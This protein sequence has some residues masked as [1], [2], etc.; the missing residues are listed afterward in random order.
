VT[1][2]SRTTLQMTFA[3]EFS[4]EQNMTDEGLA[5]DDISMKEGSCTGA[6]ERLVHVSS[7]SSH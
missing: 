6:G 2:V 7:K 5:V 4:R 3:A 1:F